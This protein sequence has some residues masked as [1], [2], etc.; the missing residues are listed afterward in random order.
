[1]TPRYLSPQ[2]VLDELGITEPREIEVEAIAQSC[3]ATIVYEPLDGCEA[4]IIGLN[5]TAII[6]VN[7]NSQRERQRFSAAH[8]L[9]HWMCDRG[10]IGFSC[11]EQMLTREWGATNPERRA[12][13]Y[14]AELLLPKRLFAPLAR[15][16]PATLAS[17]RSLAK[18][19][20]TSITATA[21]RLVDIGEHPAAV[22]FCDSAGRR[23]FVRSSLVPSELRIVE[24]PGRGSV[25]ARLLSGAAAPSAPEEV[26]A[27]D[28]IDHRDAARYCLVED[29]VR[30]PGG[31]VLSLL[32][33]KDEAQLRDLDEDEDEER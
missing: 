14:A 23:W 6:T 17:V 20:Q 12:N 15:K 9:G 11:T 16:L 26:D 3:R 21:I 22:V 19:F 10:R 27:D 32:W 4:R 33:W 1:V 28:W 2:T 18:T 25:A 13:Q 31:A 30:A 24:T 29:S 5:D 8:E 7:E